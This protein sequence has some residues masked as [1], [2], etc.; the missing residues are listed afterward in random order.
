MPDELWNEVHDIVEETGI[1][2]IPMEKNAKKQN[3]CLG[4]PY[5]QLRK[6]E[7]QKAREKRKD[8]P[9]LMQSSREEQEKKPFL[10]EQCKEVEEKNRMGKTRFLQENWKD[11]GNISCKDGHNEEKKW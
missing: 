10:Y 8:I 1:K 7:K 4:R 3:G 2:I 11:E 9:N 6:E 5:K